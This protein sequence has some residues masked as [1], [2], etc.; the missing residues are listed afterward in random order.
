[1]SGSLASQLASGAPLTALLAK[2]PCAAQ[3][4]SAGRTGFDLVVLDTEHGP[5]GGLELEHHLRA[6]D[7]AAVPALVR[8]PKGDPAG[9]GAALDAGA[10][11]VVVPHVRSAAEAEAV[12]AAAHYPPRG[13]RGF[14]LSTR[15]GGYGAAGWD[16]HV[17]RAAR[18]TVVVVQIEDAEAVER[19]AEICAVP[20]VSGMLL[21]AADLRMSL[22]RSPEPEIDAILGAARAPVLAVAATAAEAQTW[23]A[24]GAAVVVF[25]ATALIH[26]AF[27][28]AV[29]GAAASPEPE[30]LVLLPG[31]L[32]DASLWDDVAPELRAAP[33]FARIDLDDSVPEMAE[34]V[35]A[36]APA[37][38][39]LAGHS[40]GAI[41]ALAVVRRAP[42]RVSRLA[43]LNASARPASDEQLAAWR[44]LGE[45]AQTDFDGLAG[46]FATANLP[47]GRPDLADRVAAMAHAVGP[48]GLRRQL[49]AQASRP[50]SR[51]ELAKIGAPTLV[52]SGSADGVCPPA[53][54]E[55][56]AAGIP[57]AQHV[58]IDGAGHMAPLEEPAAVAA[59]LTDW[60]E[61]R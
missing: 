4:E 17:A 14:A 33:R 6:A 29:G 21:G 28:A 5:G 60:L 42:E 59:A 19:T 44:A 43:L 16:E 18:E 45:R 51:P 34:G 57:H 12:V 54:Q 31:M 15:A 30:P 3:I 36:T 49:A 55:E 52:L 20:G 23:R 11:G 22:G 27:A 7:A 40:L 50:D 10:A 37:R 13:R 58:T 41:V 47:A 24:R 61:D 1:M 32:G 46:D 35:L 8:V 25:V 48:R 53:L 2:L 26:S 9:I 39:A 38:F 56:L